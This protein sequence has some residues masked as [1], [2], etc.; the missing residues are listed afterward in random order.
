MHKPVELAASRMAVSR[1]FHLLIRLVNAIGTLFWYER[2]LSDAAT[3]Q[4]E[5]R[6]T[7]AKCY[8]PNSRIKC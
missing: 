4:K 8:S 3:R 2:R 6:E 7:R 1:I 5:T